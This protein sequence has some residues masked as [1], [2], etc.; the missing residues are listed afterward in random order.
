LICLGEHRS[1]LPE[2]RELPPV[3]DV[4]FYFAVRVSISDLAGASVR[5]GRQG[6]RVLQ[7]QQHSP[8]AATCAAMLIACLATHELEWIFEQMSDYHSVG[9]CAGA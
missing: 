3:H 2:Q 4:R 1:I 7:C 5:G 8:I 9:V 6:R